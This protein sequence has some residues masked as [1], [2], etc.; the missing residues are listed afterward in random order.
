MEVS[1]KKPAFSPR[2]AT[3]TSTP[4]ED[5][6][7]GDNFGAVNAPL[8]VSLLL[9]SVYTTGVPITTTSA[10]A[11]AQMTIDRLLSADADLPSVC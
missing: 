3:R 11:L 1:R 9:R 6:D 7:H 8:G 4:E 2:K 10:V 5:N